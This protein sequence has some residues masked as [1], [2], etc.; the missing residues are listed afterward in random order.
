[1][2]EFFF[3]TSERSVRNF[4]FN[5]SYKMLIFIA[6]QHG[7]CQGSCCIGSLHVEILSFEQECKY[8][9]RQVAR[10][11]KFDT[12]ARNSGPSLSA[13][14]HPSGPYMNFDF[15]FRICCG[16]QEVELGVKT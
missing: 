10:S 16:I 5:F 13:S 6:L 4:V 1:V 7:N 3:N 11:T 15:F 14:C 9:W 2:L 8:V 12:V